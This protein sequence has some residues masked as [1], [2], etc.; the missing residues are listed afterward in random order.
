MPLRTVAWMDGRPGAPLTFAWVILT[1]GDRPEELAIAVASI[2]RFAGAET[3][4][5]LVNNGGPASAAPADEGVRVVSFDANLG[6]PEARDR[7]ARS[8]SA[9]VIGFLDD[10]AAIT[11]DVQHAAVTAFAAQ[12]GLGAVSFRLVD[13]HGAT[14]RR[15][16][17]R[18]GRRSARRSGAVAGF[19]GGACAIRRTAY[20][21]CGGYWGLLHYGHEELDVAWRLIDRGWSIEYLADAEVFHPRSEIS[22]HPDGWRRTGRNRVLIARRNLPWPVAIAHTGAWLAIGAWRSARERCLRAY[23]DGWVSG[24]RPA[25]ERRPI[26]W[27]TVGRLTRLG[28]PPVI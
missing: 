19:L 5:V 22:R 16:V 8:T 17:P 15:H 1:M 20:V 24:W 3:E 4:I 9:D 21:D 7:A 2:R 27:A 26:G 12:P 13:Q 14:A 11:S 28:R 25:V 10:D 18:P 6:V 23:V